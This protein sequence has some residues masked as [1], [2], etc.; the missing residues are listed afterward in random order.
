MGKDCKA[1]L[2]SD[3]I[4]PVEIRVLSP[5]DTVPAVSGPKWWPGLRAITKVAEE[6][7]G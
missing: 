6:F 1:C 4:L 3:G 2:I 5:K 7:L